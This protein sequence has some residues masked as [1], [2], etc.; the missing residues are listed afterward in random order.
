MSKE[1]SDSKESNVNKENDSTEKSDFIEEFFSKENC[2]TM[3]RFS[4]RVF[5]R[6]RQ[7]NR[8]GL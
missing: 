2:L 7:T 8:V 3:R 1:I 6:K 5:L 4:P